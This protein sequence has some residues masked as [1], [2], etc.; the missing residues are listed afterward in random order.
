MAETCTMVVLIPAIPFSSKTVVATILVTDNQGTPVDGL[1]EHDFTVRC[2][3]DNLEIVVNQARAEATPPLG[4]YHV[5]LVIRNKQGEALV[6]NHELVLTFLVH[7]HNQAT[8]ELEITGR[9]LAKLTVVSDITKDESS[10]PPS[11]F[12][13]TFNQYLWQRMNTADTKIGAVAAADLVLVT[14]FVPNTPSTSSALLWALYYIAIVL[15]AASTIV[16][17]FAF[18]RWKPETGK[19]LIF[20]RNVYKYT[21][22]NAYKNELK[23][24]L[25]D[26][27]AVED[28]YAMENYRLC[29]NLEDKYRFIQFSILLLALGFLLALVS[30]VFRETHL[31]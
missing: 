16:G 3:T 5:D 6:P 22:D 24:R 18:F 26:Q 30:L 7:R 4:L 31:F 15:F 27:Q 1:T 10:Q 12:G 17:F 11:G 14:L 29:R 8:R 28:E 9:T 25:A 19:G 13:S 21:E 20:W 2:I 23:K